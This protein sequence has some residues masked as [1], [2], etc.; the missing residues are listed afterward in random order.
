L[1]VQP[2]DAGRAPVVADR[3]LNLAMRSQRPLSLIMLDID[4]FKRINDTWGHD[5]GDVVLKSFADALMETVRGSDLAARTG[6]E[7]F[8]ILLADTGIEGAHAFAER[9]RLVIM[10]LEIPVAGEVLRVTASFG[11]STCRMSHPSISAMISRADAANDQAKR[12]RAL[13]SRG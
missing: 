11:V 8:A 9:L 1:A 6:G 12:P 3:L 2:I 10:D 5:A 7:E 13:R 4:H